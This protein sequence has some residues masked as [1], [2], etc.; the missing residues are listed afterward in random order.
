MH[1][2]VWERDVASF[3]PGVGR[4]KLY[5]AEEIE[6]IMK[7]RGEVGGCSSEEKVEHRS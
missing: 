1:P 7:K 3:C 4:G 2:K 6:A 5:S